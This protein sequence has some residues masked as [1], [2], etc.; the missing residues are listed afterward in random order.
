MSNLT[1]D[2]MHKVIE[3]AKKYEPAYYID[4]I[5]ISRDEHKVLNK[6]E[7]EIIMVQVKPKHYIAIITPENW[8]NNIKPIIIEGQSSPLG[9]ITGIP[10][11]YSKAYQEELRRKQEFGEDATPCA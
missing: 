2:M 8:E 3:L 6:P 7:D 5:R 10:I 1:I 11:Q 4:L 9:A